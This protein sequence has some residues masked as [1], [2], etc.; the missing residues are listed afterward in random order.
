MKFINR[1]RERSFLEQE[2]QREGSSFIVVYGR[3]RLGKTALIREFIKDKAGAVYFQADKSSESMAI[4]L[5]RDVITRSHEK[6]FLTDLTFSSWDQLFQFYLQGLDLSEKQII[7]IDEFQYLV[8]SNPSFAS[9]LQRIWDEY[10]KERN[11]MLILCGSSVNMM[12]TEVLNYNAPLYGRRS[13]QIQVGP[14]DFISFKEFFPGADHVSSVEL[15]G[16]TGGV[17]KYI[18]FFS[19]QRSLFAQIRNS[20]LSV[21]HFLNQEARFILSEEINE[22]INYFSILKSIAGGNTT[23]SRISNDL[24][25]PLPKV[26]PYLRTLQQIGL[27]ERLVPVTEMAPHKSKKGLYRIKDQYLRFWFRYVFPY[28]SDIAMGNLDWLM[29]KIKDEFSDYLAPV[30]EEIC[31]QLVPAL[32]PGQYSR[33]GR[34]WNNHNEI[35]VVGLNPDAQRVLTGECKWSVKPVGTDVLKKLEEKSYEVDFG[36][37]VKE[38]N[39]ILF[40]KSGFT[41]ELIDSKPANCLLCAFNE[42]DLLADVSDFP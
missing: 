16:V 17:P 19:G 22:P 32:C 34:W 15:F 5:F 28:Q 18:E 24:A 2:Y 7:V 14:L 6:Q 37:Q 39:F 36:F 21:D 11:I 41:K 20:Y 10:L 29:G 1:Q 3:R 27:V 38:I 30:F 25:F 26:T 12:L 33:F 9:V 4:N 42:P 31:L 13:G 8:W 23:I 35:D 40:S